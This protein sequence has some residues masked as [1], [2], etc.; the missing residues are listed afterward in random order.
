M[1]MTVPNAPEPATGEQGEMWRQRRPLACA[2]CRRVRL[3]CDR[4]IPCSTCTK[5]GCPDLCPTGTLSPG[6]GSRIVLTDRSKLQDK[7]DAMRDRIA[8]L[9][10]A[11]AILK[12][13]PDAASPSSSSHY[14]GTTQSEADS[15]VQDTLKS[16][17]GTLID[18]DHSEFI[19][20][21][22]SSCFY[23]SNTAVMPVRRWLDSEWSCLHEASNILPVR[24]RERN[25][26][27][28]A[29]YLPGL[30]GAQAIAKAYLDMSWMFGHAAASADEVSVLLQRVYDGWSGATSMS[31]LSQVK[32]HEVAQFLM[33]MAIGTTFG[34]ED[35]PPEV[36]AQSRTYYDLASLILSV[37]SVTA[38][39]TIEGV[40]ALLLMS[41][42]ISFFD[43]SISAS[44][45]Y[46]LNGLQARLCYALGLHKD[47]STWDLTDAERQVRRGLFWDVVCWDNWI[48][49]AVGRPPTFSIFHLEAELPDDQ[50]RVLDG[51][52]K[53]H[54]SYTMWV[55][56]FTKRCLVKVT[57]QAFGTAK[58]SHGT[59]MQLDRMLRE[60]PVSDIL[61]LKNIGVPD[62]N[63]PLVL[64]MQRTIVLLLTNKTLLLLH[65]TF[66]ALA[67]M[68]CPEDPL[69][70]QYSQSVLAA[71]RSAIY[72]T[73]SARALYEQHPTTI[74]L[75]FMWNATFMSTVIFSAIVIK[76]P[77]STLAPAAWQELDRVYTL[78][79]RLAP[80]SR[81]IARVL[82]NLTRMRNSAQAVRTDRPGA[83]RCDSMPPGESLDD[84]E[85]AF[86]LGRARLVNEPGP[87]PV[88]LKRSRPPSP[89]H[90]CS[91]DSDKDS[92][93]DSVMHEAGNL[94]Q[95]WLDFTRQIAV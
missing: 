55:R 47:D 46:V 93:A 64:A 6:Q 26:K 51:N 40:R 58:V 67:I 29:R 42:Y 12:D 5:H 23:I 53:W 57:N 11:V 92:D 72:I 19:G 43:D 60:Y 91:Y 35:V 89:V 4:K 3:R 28:F 33:V 7:V 2:E 31:R 10:H 41:W 45:S 80:Q 76:C 32:P 61:R 13:G 63:V 95:A 37:D 87:A 68:E 83:Q 50:D 74:R 62:A 52:G 77:E 25:Y 39:P 15:Q 84:L 69:K 16:Q 82:P 88:P 79:E 36:Q 56:G 48:A 18:G 34:G 30:R 94:R 85:L 38:H 90:A 1:S 14:S 75:W 24:M 9:Q 54:E 27:C 44:S 71:F 21:H 65:R 49:E 22:A 66:F 81:S 73:T 20:P 70:S 78:F 8:Q 59:V 17:C 86:M